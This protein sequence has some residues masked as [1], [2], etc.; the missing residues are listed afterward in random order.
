MKNKTLW[1]ACF[2]KIG[3]KKDFQNY[4]F[5]ARLA[6]KKYKVKIRFA[7]NHI[8]KLE[9]KKFKRIVC[10]EFNNQSS[11]K[12][13]FNSPE[14]CRAKKFLKNDQSVRNLNLLNI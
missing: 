12:K 14:Y 6:I 11:A 10:L 8:I 5:Y 13:F 7:S 1:I 2:E 4:F 9:G 3:P